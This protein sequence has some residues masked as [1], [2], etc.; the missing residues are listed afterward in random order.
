MSVQSV[1]IVAEVTVKDDNA[2][3]MWNRVSRLVKP[4]RSENGNISYHALRDVDNPAH[5][6]FVEA[7]EC[8]ADFDAHLNAAHVVAHNEATRDLLEVPVRITICE[9]APESN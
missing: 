7:W 3:E 8:A 2:D 6:I 4:S 5:F 1:H 9:S